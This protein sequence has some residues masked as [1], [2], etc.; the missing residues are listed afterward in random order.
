MLRL[1]LLKLV[2]HLHLRL[3]LLHPRLDL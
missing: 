1:H 2:F 3:D